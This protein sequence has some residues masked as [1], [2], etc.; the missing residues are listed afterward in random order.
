MVD[1]V[2]VGILNIRVLLGYDTDRGL[3]TIARLL[4]KSD[5]A[6]PSHVY[7]YDGRGEEHGVS[8]RQDEDFGV[9]FSRKEGFDHLSP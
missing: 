8:Q 4:D 3:A 7:R 1:I 5:G 6:S 2:K 9:A